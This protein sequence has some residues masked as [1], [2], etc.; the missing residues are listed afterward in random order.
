MQLNNNNARVVF[1]AK[2]IY[3]IK[4]IML[5]VYKKLQTAHNDIYNN[6]IIQWRWSGI[7]LLLAQIAGWIFAQVKGT[8]PG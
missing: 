3:F 5:H 2:H 1:H 7:G 4:Y 8:G 6:V